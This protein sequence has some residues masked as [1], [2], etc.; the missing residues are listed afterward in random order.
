MRQQTIFI[1]LATILSFNAYRAHAF[2]ID[3]S[4]L[5]CDIY[6][7]KKCIVSGEPVNLCFSFTNISNGEVFILLD[8]CYDYYD[9]NRGKQTE[10]EKLK[11]SLEDC[12]G[13][14]VP[15]RDILCRPHSQILFLKQKIKPGETF[16]GEYPLHLRVSTKVDPGEYVL[17]VKS[18][19]IVHGY[20]PPENL[21]MTETTSKI[22][23]NIRESF[24]GPSLKLIVKPYNKTQLISAYDAIMK[25]AQDELKYP[26]RSWS[27]HDHLDI[28]NSIRTI[29][30]AE[31]P[32]SVPYQIDLI[33]QSEIGFRY[34][35]PAIVN[36]WNN[37]VRYATQEQIKKIIEIAEHPECK[38]DPQYEF[39]YSS[40]YTPG[41]AWAIHKW[42][43]NGSEEIQDITSEIVD[44]FPEEYPCPRRMEIGV[45]PYGK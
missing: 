35:P 27:G 37:I 1:I 6:L 12:S 11:V 21:E 22:R 39:Y 40:H 38:K 4:Y 3:I 28:P 32:L 36:T 5:E 43:A 44:R 14:Q 25:K 31:G 23:K 34:W 33:Y 19:D 29:L 20:S 24:S 42:H 45:Y 16:I 2:E 41:L 18:F 9:S 26:S 7:S 8:D 10:T 15:R 13:N 17:S 30:W